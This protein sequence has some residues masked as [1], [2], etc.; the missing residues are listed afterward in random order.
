MPDLELADRIITFLNSL[1]EVDREAVSR[2]M[3]GYVRCNRTMAE[4][5]TVQCGQIA[6]DWWHV[7]ALGILNGLCGSFDADHPNAGWGPVVAVVEDDDF[8]KI[9]RFCRTEEAKSIHKGE[10]DAGAGE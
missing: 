1:L 2:I 4:H 3:T 9:I 10:Q 5:P 8:K 7:G 6:P